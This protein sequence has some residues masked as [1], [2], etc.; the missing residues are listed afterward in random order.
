M[1]HLD[2][3]LTSQ[4][5]TQLVCK[6]SSG[7]PAAVSIY[8]FDNSQLTYLLGHA[9]GSIWCPLC[10]QPWRMSWGRGVGPSLE[11]QVEELSLL[12]PR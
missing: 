5:A 11:N 12:A 7:L 10:W 8:M 2:L 6:V 4:G 9:V 1:N 3:F